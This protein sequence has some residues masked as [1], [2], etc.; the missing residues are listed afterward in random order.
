MYCMTQER[1]RWLFLTPRLESVTDKTKELTPPLIKQ[2]WDFMQSQLGQ[3]EKR[4]QTVGTFVSLANDTTVNGFWK[5]HVTANLRT[6]KAYK[7]LGLLSPC[8]EKKYMDSMFFAERTLFDTF[9]QDLLSMS[10]NLLLALCVSQI[11]IQY[12]PSL[13][14]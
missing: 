14:V 9:I 13:Y 6:R 1:G 7:I 8:W 5:D 3:G 4:G 10:V 11:P 2:V 12:A